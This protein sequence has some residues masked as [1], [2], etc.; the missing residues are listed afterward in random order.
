MIQTHLFTV[1]W[2]QGGDDDNGDYTEKEEKAVGEETEIGE[3]RLINW[4]ESL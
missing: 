2:Y 1:T 3:E 4:R